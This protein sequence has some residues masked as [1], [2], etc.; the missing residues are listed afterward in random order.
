M[1]T[2]AIPTARRLLRVDLPILPNPWIANFFI[3]ALLEKFD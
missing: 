1:A 3:V 2:G